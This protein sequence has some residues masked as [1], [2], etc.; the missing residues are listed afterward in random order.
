MC[1][2]VAS[3]VLTGCFFLS[4]AAPENDQLLNIPDFVTENILFSLVSVA[5]LLLTLF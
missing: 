1:G 3:D 5:D 2:V 4:V